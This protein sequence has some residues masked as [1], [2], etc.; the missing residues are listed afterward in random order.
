MTNPDE[1][2]MSELVESLQVFAEGEARWAQLMR[3]FSRHPF[4][5]MRIDGVGQPGRPP[6]ECSPAL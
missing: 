1:A 6:A 4:S 5:P 3:K 2:Q